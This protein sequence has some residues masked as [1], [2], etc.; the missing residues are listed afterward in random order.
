VLDTISNSVYVGQFGAGRLGDHDTIMSECFCV[1]T[2]GA[3][4]AKRIPIGRW[5]K[6]YAQRTVRARRRCAIW[7]S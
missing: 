5:W 6:R 2:T 7:A 4:M 1:P 3:R